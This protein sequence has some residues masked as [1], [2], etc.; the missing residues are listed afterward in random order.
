[1]AVITMGWPAL[2]AST[3]RWLRDPTT[4]LS[5]RWPGRRVA[6]RRAQAP[7]FSLCS[8]SLFVISLP[9]C[10]VLGPVRFTQ[11]ELLARPLL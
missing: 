2:R 6:R 10:L 11:H 4:D 1:M 5:E 8:A 7:A 9:A 3:R